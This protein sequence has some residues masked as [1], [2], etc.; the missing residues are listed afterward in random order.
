MY[1]SKVYFIINVIKFHFNV[2]KKGILILKYLKW[3]CI[4]LIKRVLYCKCIV[5]CTYVYLEKVY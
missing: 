5:S 3:Y 4:V 2:L 1:F